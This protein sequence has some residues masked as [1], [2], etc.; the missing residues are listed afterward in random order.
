MRL[1][2]LRRDD[3][4]IEIETRI[5]HCIGALRGGLL[6]LDD[7][8]TSGSSATKNRR[9]GQVRL[10]PPH[11][12]FK[13][14]SSLD[15]RQ[16]FFRCLLPSLQGMDSAR[17]QWEVGHLFARTRHASAYLARLNTRY[18]PLP[19]QAT[20]VSCMTKHVQLVGDLLEIR[21]LVHF[22]SVLIMDRLPVIANLQYHQR[23]RQELRD[24]RASVPESGPH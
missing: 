7:I 2:S 23:R 10:N 24:Q 19:L 15:V 16:C 21:V 18:Y 13:A 1:S 20:T 9:E 11:E 6:V 3:T 12:H 8:L 22:I 5:A 17:L 4:R 14:T